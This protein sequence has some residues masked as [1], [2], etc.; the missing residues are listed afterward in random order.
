[1]DKCGPKPPVQSSSLNC[2]WPSPAQS[3]LVSGP[4]GTHDLIYFR[5][6]TVYMF[7]NGGLF[8]DERRGLSF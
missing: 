5:S 4:V 7:R 8:F 2:C 1:L 3:L 6:K